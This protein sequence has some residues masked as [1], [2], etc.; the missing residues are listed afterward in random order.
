MFLPDLLEITSLAS[1]LR[2]CEVTSLEG[3]SAIPQPSASWLPLRAWEKC[4]RK[5]GSGWRSFTTACF[6]QTYEIGRAHV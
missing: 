4:Y 1:A 5:Y 3:L 2:T 6:K